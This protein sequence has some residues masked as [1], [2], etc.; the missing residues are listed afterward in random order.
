MRTLPLILT[1]AVALAACDQQR[2][3]KLEEGLSTEADVRRQFGEPT[4]I[5]EKADGSKL[6]EYPRQPEGSTNYL[7]VIGADGTMSSLRQLLTPANFARVQ[8][9]MDQT[10]VRRMLGKPART[11]RYAMKP[12][13]DVWEWR[14]RDGT[15]SK[16]FTVTFDRQARVL[17]TATAEDPRDVTPK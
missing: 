8:A 6:F 2:I 4:L 17:S 15:Q 10:E 14:F 7:I 12:D 9:G 13:E 11:Q 3:E 5:T 1:M 16:L